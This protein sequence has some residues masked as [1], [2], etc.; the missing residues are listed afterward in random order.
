MTAREIHERMLAILKD[1]DDFLHRLAEYD[2]LKECREGFWL[3]A[4][5]ANGSF[6]NYYA[7]RSWEHQVKMN[8]IR[9]RIAERLTQ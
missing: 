6:D 9:A 3:R 5:M 8:A 7:P 2:A 1:K 4:K